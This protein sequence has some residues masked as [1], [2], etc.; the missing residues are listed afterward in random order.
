M[1]EDRLPQ[2]FV[3]QLSPR[4][5]QLFHSE[6]QMVLRST[7]RLLILSLVFF[8][9]ATFHLDRKELCMRCLPLKWLETVKES[10]ASSPVHE[11]D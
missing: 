5:L 10:E 4:G 11:R 8:C 6:G 9:V 3:C 1:S 2:A 7:E